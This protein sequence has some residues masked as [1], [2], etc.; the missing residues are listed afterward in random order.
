MFRPFLILIHFTLY[1]AVYGTLDIG[2]ARVDVDVYMSLDR[3]A[4]ST[5]SATASIVSTTKTSDFD[6]PTEYSEPTHPPPHPYSK[7]TSYIG[8]AWDELRS[9][10]RDSETEI[11]T[12]TTDLDSPTTLFMV[13]TTPPIADAT[14]QYTD[15]T[16]SPL[17][18]YSKATSYVVS[19]WDELHDD[20]SLDTESS[21]SAPNLA[22][23]ATTLAT[24]CSETPTI[25]DAAQPS[26][27]G[28][29]SPS[30]SAHATGTKTCNGGGTAQHSLFVTTTSN[31]SCSAHPSNSFDS[32]GTNTWVWP[33]IV[34]AGPF[35]SMHPNSSNNTSSPVVQ[36]GKAEGKPFV[37]MWTC[38]VFGG[39]I[40]AVEV[41]GML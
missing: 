37:T 35:P 14:S 12:E 1:E 34:S 5:F 17:H 8:S 30:Q 41:R 28:L 19:V 36:S 24:T 27:V 38:C 3:Q 2:P 29:T 33:S 22:N 10:L 13:S 18:L 16:Q 9:G 6:A 32:N 20:T 11:E 40:L 26:I 4:S 7:A 31:A 23:V 21:T 25:R 15:S 39:L